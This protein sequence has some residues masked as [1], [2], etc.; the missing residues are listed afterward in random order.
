VGP[1]YKSPKVEVP[2]DYRA[3]TVPK[4]EAPIIDTNWWE[5]FRDPQLHTLVRTAF[6]QNKDLRLAIARV[7]AARAQLGIVGADQ[8][9]KVGAGFSGT[10]TLG[11]ETGARPVPLG[12]DRTAHLYRLG[13]TFAWEIDLWGKCRRATEAARA[14]LLAAEEARQAIA[15]SLVSSVAQAYLQLRELDLDLQISRSTLASRQETARI[16][17]VLYRNGLAN[18][19]DLRQAE[20]AVAATAAAPPDLERA[21]AQS[22][23]ALGSLLGQYPGPVAG[24]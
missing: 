2:G 13:F 10:A 16:V 19:L 11:S 9:P 24:L 18:E 23:N 15:I 14:Q 20:G 1:K 17:G 8:Y 12:E 4:E 7:D 6:D 22:E 5:L 3:A 21:I